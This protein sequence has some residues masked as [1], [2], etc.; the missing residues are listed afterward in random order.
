MST[1][2]M[3]DLGAVDV[4]QQIDPPPLAL[5]H[6]HSG[7]R[8]RLLREFQ[9]SIAASRTA[10]VA[11][12]TD[13]A[14]AVHGFRKALR[15]GRALMAL[16]RTQMRK[17]DYKH[18]VDALRDVR[19]S[20]SVAR[21]H[22]VAPGV[23]A[24]MILTDGERAAANEALFSAR[25]CAPSV[26]DIEALLR[27]GASAAFTQ[28]ESFEAALPLLKEKDLIVGLARTYRDARRARRKAKT[29]LRAFHRFR[30]RLKELAYQL[31]FITAFGGHRIRTIADSY[32]GILVPSGDVADLLMV[33][34]FLATYQDNTHSADVHALADVVMDQIEQG[35]YMQRRASKDLF[36]VSSKR[37]ARRIR[38]ALRKDNAPPSTPIENSDPGDL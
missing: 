28:S 34:E 6:D 11:S 37:F 13:L 25:Q 19:R 30:R 5:G 10:A 16:A 32:A 17:D 36:E 1:I 18:I 12:S 7:A 22:A 21:D 33:R 15:R 20:V 35:A 23:V 2:P 26:D 24:A 9:A 31:E 14:D 4:A 38:K 27:D 29:S 3:S 8:E